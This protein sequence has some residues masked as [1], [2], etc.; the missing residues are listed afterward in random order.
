MEELARQSLSRS[1]ALEL[2]LSEG[3]WTVMADRHGFETAILNLVVNARDA[4]PRGGLVRI[5]SANVTQTVF[6]GEGAAPAPGSEFVRVTVSDTGIGMTR[7][8]AARAA[9][10]LFTTK[11]AGKGTGLGLY[12]VTTFATGAGGRV[13]IDSEPGRG[14]TVRLYL[15]RHGADTSGIP[16]AP[17]RGVMT[18]AQGRGEMVVVVENEPEILTYAVEGLEELGYRAVGAPDAS[19]ALTCL[20]ETCGVSVLFT[21]IGLPGI[22]GRQLASE[23]QR[24]YPELCVIYASGS[25]VVGA[26]DTGHGRARTPFILKPY[27][28]DQVGRL[29]REALA[30]SSA[31]EGPDVPA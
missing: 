2:V 11:P 7:E 17:R 6:L 23:A 18:S 13:E 15:P 19:S 28:M 16:D 29:I 4:M 24:R 20:E 8:V 14:T 21:D 3:I 10:P 1:T 27:S 5:E 25:P 31:M 22:D 26:D 9:E 12:Q 30:D